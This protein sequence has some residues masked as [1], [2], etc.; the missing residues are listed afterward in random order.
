[1]I[2]S[3]YAYNEIDPV[4]GSRDFYSALHVPFKGD[5]EAINCN[6]ECLIFSFLM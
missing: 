6:F 4:L 2:S 5:T 1:M 3:I